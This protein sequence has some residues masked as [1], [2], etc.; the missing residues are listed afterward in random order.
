M[1]KKFTLDIWKKCLYELY[2]N[3][4]VANFFTYI[5]IIQILID[6]KKIFLFAPNIHIKIIFERNYYNKFI[7]TMKKYVGNNYSVVFKVGFI[8]IKDHKKILIKNSCFKVTNFKNVN[9]DIKKFITTNKNKKFFFYLNINNTVK[10][11]NLD[12]IL[13]NLK[14]S[15]F[16][17]IVSNLTFLLL[18]KFEY[19]D[20][21]NKFDT[22]ILFEKEY[23]AGF[24][25]LLKRNSDKIKPFLENKN[26]LFLSETP[27]NIL[28][29]YFLKIIND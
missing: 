2:K 28:R 15:S 19:K 1:N 26:V 22:L 3:V 18:S 23:T 4:S 14:S 10:K 8:Y 9:Y 13:L 6:K 5:D 16:K 20:V 24:Y 7:N 29:E 12:N 11:N 25:F 21:F 17:F 27:L